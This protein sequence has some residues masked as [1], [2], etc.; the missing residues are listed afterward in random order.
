MTASTPFDP[1]AIDAALRLVVEDVAPDARYLAKY[2]G[3]LIL[4]DPGSDT[5]IGGIFAYGAHVSL[6]FSRGAFLDDPHGH[7][8][9]RGRLRRHL[10]FR[11]VADV[12][13]KD[14]RGFLKQAIVR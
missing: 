13:A 6:E 8:E 9:G 1:A 14:A 3:E 7:L 11:S 10:K 12:A 2:G 5:A 4:P